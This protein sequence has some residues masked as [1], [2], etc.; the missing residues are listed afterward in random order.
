MHS[1]WDKKQFGQL[2]SCVNG[3][4][5]QK[6]KLNRANELSTNRSQKLSALPKV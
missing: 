1:T 2:K 3:M 4:P 5:R 6:S